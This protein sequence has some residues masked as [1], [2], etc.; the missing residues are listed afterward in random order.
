MLRRSLRALCEW[1]ARQSVLNVSGKQTTMS[2][3]DTVVAGYLQAPP[4]RMLKVHHKTRLAYPRL[5]AT[6]RLLTAAARRKLGLV[7]TPK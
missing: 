1:R 2:D 3:Y 5:K 7:S 6:E 4:T